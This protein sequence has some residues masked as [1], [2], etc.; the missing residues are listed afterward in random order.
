MRRAVVCSIAVG[1]SAAFPAS[2]QFAHP[3]HRGGGSP[4]AVVLP[5]D[6]GTSLGG[7]PAGLGWVRG[8]EADFLHTGFF[9]DL[10]TD[11]NALYLAG[12][13][14]PAGARRRVRLG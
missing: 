7:N 4:R 14:G 12:G 8:L 13:A 9:K 6:D 11:A 3:S 10:H 1:I 2:A 5:A